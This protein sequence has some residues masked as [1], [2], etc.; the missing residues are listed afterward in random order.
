MSG[1]FSYLK[2]AAVIPFAPILIVKDVITGDT[3]KY[4]TEDNKN[5]R[6]RVEYDDNGLEEMLDKKLD[7]HTSSL[8]SY[9]H[10][11]LEDY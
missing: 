2:Y 6:M 3:E 7:K 10:N 8:K 1:F 5:K 9:I 11:K 4:K